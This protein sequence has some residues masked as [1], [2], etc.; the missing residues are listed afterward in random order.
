LVVV[1]FVGDRDQDR[2][3]AIPIH[4]LRGIGQ[5]FMLAGGR[6]ALA[7]LEGLAAM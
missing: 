5:P 1:G 7:G 4:Y 6:L 3:D 2:A